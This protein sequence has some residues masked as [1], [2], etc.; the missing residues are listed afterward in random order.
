VTQPIVDREPV[1]LPTLTGH[2]GDLWNT[3]IELSEYHPGE[4]TLIGGQMVFLHGLEH[5]VSPPRMS[6]DLDLLVNARIVPGAVAAFVETLEGLRFEQDGISPDGIA[7]RY[8]RGGVY[9]D[10]LAPDGLGDRVDLTTTPPG[11][12]LQVPGGTQALERTELLPV[13]TA[14]STGQVPRPNLLGAIVGKAL[15]VGVDDLPDAQRSDFVFLL[16]LVDDPF[17]MA[18]QLTKTDR[19]RLRKRGELLDQGHRVWRQLEPEDR[20]RAQATLRILT[21]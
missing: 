17:T 15:A 2:T 9:V 7:H 8:R 6:T 1:M 11:R 12:T 10:V 21:R 19:R 18:E 16:S 20:D 5:G 13:A 4:W 14:T 3:L